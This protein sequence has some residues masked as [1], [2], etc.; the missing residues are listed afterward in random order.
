MRLSIY[1]DDDIG[2]TLVDLLTI[3]LLVFLLVIVKLT[4]SVLRVDFSSRENTFTGGMVRPSFLVA[5]VNFSDSD[6]IYI[7]KQGESSL[8][9]DAAV[10]GLPSYIFADLLGFIEYGKAE[11]ENEGYPVFQLKL[12]EKQKI[13]NTMIIN[14]AGEKGEINRK[15]LDNI[16]AQ[17]EIEYEIE[18][19][20][21]NLPASIKLLER[22]K[23]Y[24]ES[25]EREGRK[26]IVCG[27]LI[28][29]DVTEGLSSDY[30]FIFD[31]LATSM[32]D[33]VYLGEF[34]PEKRAQ[35]LKLNQG[36]EAYA[37]YNKWRNGK[38]EAGTLPPF[39]KYKKARKLYI[40][41]A[42]AANDMPPTWIKK[43]FLNK[44]G[45]TLKIIGSK[46]A[47]SIESKKIN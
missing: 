20:E 37:Y 3:L 13:I 33:F 29:I 46:G 11:L 30:K 38:I 17:M 40:E 31:T 21:K 10:F 6:N 34:D 16:F 45:V 32:M 23:I 4:F 1:A 36:E 15:I 12:A 25:M 41:K 44:I 14:N 7:Y 27:D 42:V 9:K 39:A 28:I 8:N 47:M 26:F 18:K 22:P 19:F 35:F 43:L 2:D 24:Y 5:P